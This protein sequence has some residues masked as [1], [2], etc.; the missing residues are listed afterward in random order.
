MRAAR[1]RACQAGA[2][3]NIGRRRGG[4]TLFVEACERVISADVSSNATVS[5]VVV[6]EKSYN[7]R[8]YSLGVTP[9]NCLNTRVM[10]E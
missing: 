6:E 8:R 4:Q 7:A 9:R 5:R 10:W 1:A 2:L 3:A